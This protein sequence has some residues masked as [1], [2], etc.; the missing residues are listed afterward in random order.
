MLGP[1]ILQM[2]SGGNVLKAWGG[3]GYVPGWPGRLQSL[4][5][6]RQGNVWISGTDLGDSILKFSSDGKLL[7][8]FGH[9]WPKGREFQQDNQQPEVLPGIEDFALD[10]DAREIYIADGSR[11]RRKRALCGTATLD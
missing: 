5:A 9:R 11:F 8:G 2:D 4:V 10:E 1:E 7:W 6:D 3:R